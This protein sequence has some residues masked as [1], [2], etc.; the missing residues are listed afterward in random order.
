MRLHFGNPGYIKLNA[1]C[2]LIDIPIYVP[3]ITKLSEMDLSHLLSGL[4]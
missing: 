4:N 1:L 2:L 3:A